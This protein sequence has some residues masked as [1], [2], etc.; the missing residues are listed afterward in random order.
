MDVKPVIE[1]YESG[2]IERESWYL[3]GSLHRI[4]GPAYISYYK[5]GK[6]KREEW[7]LDGTYHRVDGP[8]YISYYESNQTRREDWYLNDKESNHKEWLIANNL[9][10]P[11]NTWS[12]EEKGIMEIIMDVKPTIEYYKSG[13]IQREDWY[14]SCK[15]HRLDGPA[16]LLYYKSGQKQREDWYLNGISHRLDGPADIWYYESGKV[17]RELWY[18]NGGDSGEDIWDLMAE[19]AGEYPEWKKDWERFLTEQEIETRPRFILWCEG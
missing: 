13:Q 7:F 3:N 15:F 10:K 11:Y 17:E 4:D 5:S 19:M 18:L 9:Y 12:D 2:E 14:L 6:K 16:Y 8:A 1:Y